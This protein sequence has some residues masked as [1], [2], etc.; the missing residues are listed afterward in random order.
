MRNVATFFGGA[1]EISGF[2]A[3]FSLPS[4]TGAERKKLVDCID[5]WLHCT[6]F[7]N[8]LFMSNLEKKSLFAKRF[9]ESSIINVIDPVSAQREEHRRVGHFFLAS[10]KKN[11]NKLLDTDTI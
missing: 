8:V 4:F 1:G 10:Y 2:Q 3:R 11:Y 6:V 7:I 9:P 5:L